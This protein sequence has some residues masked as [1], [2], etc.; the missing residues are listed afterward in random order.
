MS[1]DHV[2]LSS[3]PTPSTSQGSASNRP[4]LG[5]HF[6]CCG[7]YARIYRNADQTAYVGHCPRCTRR[8]QVNIAPGGSDQRFFSVY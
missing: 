2:D 8:L 6:A 1:G 5:V 7:A 3:E 4:F